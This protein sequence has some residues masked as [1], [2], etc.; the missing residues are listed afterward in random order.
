MSQLIKAYYYIKNPNKK[1]RERKDE[2]KKDIQ[3]LFKLVEEDYISQYNIPYI[4]ADYI[5][6][7]T[8]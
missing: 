5:D 8:I 2:Q 4:T 3:K 7:Y 1:T 6:E